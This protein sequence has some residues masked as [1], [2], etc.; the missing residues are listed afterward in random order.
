MAVDGTGALGRVLAARTAIS[1]AIDSIAAA[2]DSWNALPSTDVAEA[3]GEALRLRALAEG[4]GMELLI[5]AS[6]R[7]VIAE[8]VWH[9]PA[10]WVRAQADDAGAPVPPAVAKHYEDVAR[11]AERTDVDVSA[12]RAAVTRGA[13]SIAIAAPLRSDLDLIASRVSGPVA[14]TAIGAMVE[15]ACTGASAG[16]LRAAREAVIA[17]YG[18]EGEFEERQ[19]HAYDHREMTSWR[20][21][22]HDRN[23]CVLA[24]D[25]AGRAAVDAA[26]AALA[27]P[28][29]TALDEHGGIFEADVRSAGQR[30]ADALVEMCRVVAT[31]PTLLTHARPTSAAKAQV[32]VT[33]RLS[34]LVSGLG[35]GADA[36]GLPLPPSAVRRLCCDADIIPAVLGTDSELLDLGR[37]SRLATRAQRRAL[38]H[39]D[40]CCTF[41][42]CTRP[43]S[44]CDAHHLTSWLDGGRTDLDNLALLCTHHHTVVHVRGY[45]G[46][47]DATGAV[48]WARP[49]AGAR[50]ATSPLSAGAT[51]SATSTTPTSST[52]RTQPPSPTLTTAGDRTGPRS[53][54]P[55]RSELAEVAPAAPENPSPKT[56]PPGRPSASPRSRTAPHVSYL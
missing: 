22:D 53:R 45:A 29:P 27:A 2:T 52:G 3:F 19:R 34:G 6:S 41:P 18:D 10:D 4:L 49:R 30:R 31:D 55:N 48:Q 37:E 21:D 15:A 16:E 36:A 32:I 38:T 54:P 23:V 28:F 24:L 5:E 7:G 14:A 44:W 35:F 47:V 43:A 46:W 51:G 26:M 9:K 1:A 56:G 42:A 12:Y 11:Y 13:L 17:S 40:R 39:R 25:N 20:R 50:R 8:S 33:M